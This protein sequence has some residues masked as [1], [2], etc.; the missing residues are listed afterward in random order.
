[1]TAL[2]ENVFSNVSRVSRRFVVF[3]KPITVMPS[4]IEFSFSSR[5]LYGPSTV[6]VRNGVE[7]GAGNKWPA[8]RKLLGRQKRFSLINN[9][10]SIYFYDVLARP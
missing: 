5:T 3:V 10:Y 8:K 2:G 6:A 9:G 7:M 4:L 1:M